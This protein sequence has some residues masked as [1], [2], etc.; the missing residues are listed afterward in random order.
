MHPIQ[1]GLRINPA[2][3]PPDESL[4][5]VAIPQP[6]PPWIIN[7]TGWLMVECVEV[8]LKLA[9]S[10]ALTHVKSVFFAANAY[11]Q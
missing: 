11:A 5:T 6:V 4:W 3:Q 7:L 8:H 9:I 1:F 2:P 10:P